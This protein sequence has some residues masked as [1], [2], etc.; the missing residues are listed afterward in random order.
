MLVKITP[1]D[2]GHR[3]SRSDISMV[4]IEDH[5]SSTENQ[6]F[7]KFLDSWSHYPLSSSSKYCL[8]YVVS[9]PNELTLCKPDI[10]K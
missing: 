2:L 4:Y 7:T 3:W 5:A 9:Q 8:T 1:W 10:M 6:P